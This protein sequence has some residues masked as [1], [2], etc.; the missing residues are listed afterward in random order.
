M[1]RIFSL[2]AALTAVCAIATAQIADDIYGDNPA[3][4]Q[5]AQSAPQA[6]RIAEISDSLAFVRAAKALERG[7]WVLQAESIN[8]TYSAYTAYAIDGNR[9]FLFV[10]GNKGMLQTAIIEALPGLNGMGGV[11]LNGNVENPR[12]STDKKGNPV[13]T[14]NLVGTDINADV[15]LTLYKGSNTAQALVM[16][17]FGGEPLTIKGQLL[18]Y[19]KPRD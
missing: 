8:F 14:Y 6:K 11:S 10:Q 18:P 5:V 3:P 16:P 19:V 15:T 4:A 17:A 2:L 1:R 12:L 7:Y 13:F 9:N